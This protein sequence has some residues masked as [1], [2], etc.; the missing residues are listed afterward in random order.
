MGMHLQVFVGPYVKCRTKL[1]PRT[2]TIIECREHFDG[3]TNRSRT[4][5]GRFCPQCG[6][7]KTEFQHTWPDEKDA[8]VQWWDVEDEIGERLCCPHEAI[9][10]D[11]QYEHHYWLSNF[12]GSGKTCGHDEALE[13]TALS[14]E[15]IDADLSAMKEEHAEELQTLERE[16]GKE[17]VNLVW[18]VLPYWM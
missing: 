3:S 11:E 16:Y 15:N 1:V 8:A 5:E 14:K 17:N 7:Q 18:G 4:G 10:R 6:T 9:Q 2:E 12:T 13:P